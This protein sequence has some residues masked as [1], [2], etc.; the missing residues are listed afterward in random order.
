MRSVS[1]EIL[2]ATSERR[3]TENTATSL[4]RSK[5]W[6]RCSRKNRRNN[7]PA[8]TPEAYWRWAVFVPFLDELLEQ[9]M[10]RFPALT[11]Q[12]LIW[13]K[14][15]PK[16]L[17]KNHQQTK[18][19]KTQVKMIMFVVSF[20]PPPFWKILDPPLRG[21]PTLRTTNGRPQVQ[22]QDCWLQQSGVVCCLAHGQ[23]RNRYFCWPTE[24]YPSGQGGSTER[25][26]S[27]EKKEA[28]LPAWPWL[29]SR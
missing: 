24:S 2:S 15:L 13:L 6:P 22:D 11:A 18:L 5:R 10:S 4:R 28:R 20:K 1:S 27:P 19:S 25:Y 21:Y 26:W 16:S 14:P 8:D 7:V 23:E 17:Q 29:W 9:L 12:A 3:Q